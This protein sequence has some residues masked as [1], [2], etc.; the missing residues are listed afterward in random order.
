MFM[1]AQ[2]V[3]NV[4]KY[5]RELILFIIFILK[6]QYVILHGKYVYLNNCAHF[7]LIGAFPTRI[8]SHRRKIPYK[9][10]RIIENRIN[11]IKLYDEFFLSISI[12]N[13][14]E[15]CI[16]AMMNSGIGI[17]IQGKICKLF[18]PFKILLFSKNL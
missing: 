12:R 10:C 8:P 15:N 6:L 7:F 11:A 9:S 16:K 2:T 5:R 14:S 18:L 17:H 4:L 3:I 1:R 13:K